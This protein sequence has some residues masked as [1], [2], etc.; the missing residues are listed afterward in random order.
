MAA[1]ILGVVSLFT[2][3]T[4]DQ[5]IRTHILVESVVQFLIAIGFTA[6]SITAFLPVN[7]ESAGP[8]EKHFRIGL[9]IQS[10]AS[11]IDIIYA[12]SGIIYQT[13]ITYVVSGRGSNIRFNAKTYP[14]FLK[15]GSYCMFII[16]RHRI[17][18]VM[19]KSSHNVS[20]HETNPALDC[21]FDVCSGP[22]IA[23]HNEY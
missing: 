2:I 14:A 12:D 15:T 22:D 6:L 9:A 1:V 23:S 17:S 18:T 10:L 8:I 20:P 13:I 19:Q 21:N 11:I 5:R 16:G 4:I 3:M 7:R